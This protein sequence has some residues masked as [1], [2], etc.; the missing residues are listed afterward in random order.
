M[1]KEKLFNLLQTYIPMPAIITLLGAVAFGVLTCSNT[2][3][4]INNKLGNQQMVLDAHTGHMDKEDVILD[5]LKTDVTT[6]RVQ[7]AQMQKQIDHLP[8]N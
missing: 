6:L 4:Q 2:L 5:I 1:D 3:N 7:T 8:R